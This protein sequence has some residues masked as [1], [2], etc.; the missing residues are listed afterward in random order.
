MHVVIA[1]CGRVGSTLARELTAI[2][3]SVAVIDRRAET[4][5]RL[6]DDFTGDT[7][8]GVG[9]DRDLLR[10]PRLRPRKGP[11]L[12]CD[13]AAHERESVDRHVVGPSGLSQAPGEIREVERTVRHPNDAHDRLL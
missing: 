4:F 12:Q 1:G 11:V 3:H 7:Y 13:R 9:F 2:G 10:S 8:V 6:G 5:A